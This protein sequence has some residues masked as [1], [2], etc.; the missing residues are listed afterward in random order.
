M[1]IYFIS[2]LWERCRTDDWYNTANLFLIFQ[3]SVGHFK[4][5]SSRRPRCHHAQNTHNCEKIW[6]NLFRCLCLVML[7]DHIVGMLT[8]SCRVFL[9]FQAENGWPTW[10][11]KCPCPYLIPPSFL[12][13]LVSWWVSLS[14]EFLCS[15]WITVQNRLS[16]SSVRASYWQGYSWWLIHRIMNQQT[17]NADYHLICCIALS[18][19]YSSPCPLCLFVQQDKAELRSVSPETETFHKEV[20]HVGHLAREIHLNRR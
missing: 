9:H 17:W 18:P 5:S 7:L 15:N 3:A 12:L 14:V 11:L 2:C 8:F 6:S 16:L 10:P 20:A 13:P 19:S 4:I 1:N